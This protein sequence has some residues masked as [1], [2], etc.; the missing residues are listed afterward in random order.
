MRLAL[1]VVSPTARRGADV[2]LEADPATPMAD[3]AAEL[4]RFISGS[5]TEPH[6]AHGAQ[7]LR[8]PGPRSQGSL[9]MSSPFPDVLPDAAP[10][11]VPLYVNYQPIPP[12]LTLAEAP[13][14][15]GAVVSLGS[16][17]GCV[18]PESA[19]LAELRV[20]SGPMAGAIHRLGTGQAD[21]GGGDTAGFR[22]RDPAIPG[23]ALRVY[24][25]G[26]GGCQVAPYEGV[27]ATLDREPLTAPAQWRPG[28]QI[29]VGNTLLGLAPYELP[30]AALQPSK[31]GSGVDFNRPPRLLPPERI[32]RFQLPVPPSAAERRPLP[33][34]MAALP[35]VLGVVM[36]F[37]LRQVYLLAMAG[38]S[39]VMLVGS[40]LS[41]RSHSR[42]ANA[43]QLAEYENHRARIEHDARQALQAERAERRDQFPDPATVLSIASGPRRRLWERRR[44]DP[45]YLVLR[46][47]TADLPSA[48]ELTDPEQDEHRRQVVWLVPD[49]PV[50]ISLPER[51]VVGVAGPGDTP[52][53]AGRW[54]VA[55]AATLHSPNDLKIYLLTDS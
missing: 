33:I 47:G 55:Q 20:T 21:I 52:R 23:L 28:Q 5:F 11:P 19:G 18:H 4:E 48:V 41:E 16:P 17:D 36:A 6:P 39:P 43:R 50:T 29:A 40:H 31:D 42:K 26:R 9:A 12:Q 35:L 27:R 24:V 15:D 53:A 51:K 13:I 7:V 49:A 44:T 2:V 25:D 1:T 46:V 54:L 3:V 30:D 34:L 22:I 32:T 10:L 38:L 45:D 8:F 14:R 37:A